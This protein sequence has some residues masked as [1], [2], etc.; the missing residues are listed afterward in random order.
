MALIFN[1]VTTSR[2]LQP[3]SLLPVILFS[4]MLLLVNT[5]SAQAAGVK[6]E[7]TPSGSV[8]LSLFSDNNVSFLYPKPWF[9]QRIAGQDSLVVLSNDQSALMAATGTGGTPTLTKGQIVVEVFAG[10]TAANQV[11]SLKTSGNAVDV[12]KGLVKTASS[13]T[14]YGTPESIA[15]ISNTDAAQ[16]SATDTATK[17]DGIVM[18]LSPNDYPVIVVGLFSQNQ[19]AANQSLITGIASTIQPGTALR[20]PAT[21]TAPNPTSIPSS[22][23]SQTFNNKV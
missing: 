20:I 19:L 3:H 5:A 12:L 16:V 23:L 2:R 1:R 17:D 6:T 14:T 8:A 11:A 15:L 21:A 9:K 13:A 10:S 22:S 4:G 7:G 18:L